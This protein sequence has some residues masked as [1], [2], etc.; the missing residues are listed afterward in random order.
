MAKGR[1]VALVIIGIMLLTAVMPQLA[2]ADYT[3]SDEPT[4]WSPYDGATEIGPS[5]VF[6]FYYPVPVAPDLPYAYQMQYRT[7]TGTYTLPLFDS[8]YVIPVNWGNLQPVYPE[9][10]FDYGETYYWRVRIQDD[11][12]YWTGWSHETSFTVIVN[13]PPS[14][15]ENF[16]PDDNATGVSLPLT[17]QACEFRDPNAS[18]LVLGEAD[19]H[20]ASLWQVTATSGNYASPAFDSGRVT[21]DLTS[22][23][24]PVGNL[25]VNTKYYW[26]VRYQDSYGNWSAYSPE[27]SFTTGTTTA[28]VAVQQPV[29]ESPYGGATEISP[30]QKLKASAFQGAAGRT[31]FASRWQVAGPGANQIDPV[32]GR[33]NESLYDSGIDTN[34]KLEIAMPVGLLGYGRTYYWH[35][36]YQDDT[37][38]WSAWSAETSFTLVGNSA[39]SSPRNIEPLDVTGALAV[40]LTP[41][42]KASDFSDPD[43]SVYVALTDSHAASQWQVTATAGNYSDNVCTWDSGVASPTTSA[44]VPAGKLAAGTKYYW[45][46]RYRDSQNSWSG[47]SSETSFTTKALTVPTASFSADKTEVTAGTDLVTFTDNSTPAGEITAWSWNF[48]DGTTENWTTLTR[49]SNGQISHK[50]TIGGTQTVKLTVYNGAAPEGKAQTADIVV[51]AKP[52][53]NILGPATAKAGKE[54][55]FTDDST[56]SQDITSWEWQFDDGTTVQWTAAQR[57]AAG[58]QIKHAFK[59]AEKHTVSLLVKGDLGESY[60]NKQITVTG[61]G[62]FRFGLWMIG[63]AVAAV[64]V[65]AGVVYLLRARKGK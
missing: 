6:I 57:E 13:S 26:H 52:E 58:G 2:V 65:V 9:G 44:T 30:D 16:E 51:H 48:G 4:N 5:H 23:S 36:K 32:T 62:G 56:P 38:A 24:V 43:I 53:A 18:E 8:G 1:I 28:V 11:K 49:P 64:V 35:V 14:Q 29:N 10:V 27:T 21:A 47:Y 41:V 22:M 50:Y 42:L 31:H 54:V 3:L 39:P 59:T 25:A 20:A 33:Y 15:P 19:T 17:L 55:T 45:H 7:P 46:V 63:V 61:G 37:G 12:G 34:N 40:S 60:Y